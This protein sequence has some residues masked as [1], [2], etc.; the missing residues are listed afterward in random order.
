MGGWSTQWDVLGIFTAGVTTVGMVT[1]SRLGQQGKPLETT[2]RGGSSTR[3][4]NE[5]WLFF[6]LEHGLHNNW[7]YQKGNMALGSIA[8]RYFDWREFQETKNSSQHCVFILDVWGSEHF[9]CGV[10]SICYHLISYTDF[11]WC[12]QVFPSELLFPANLLRS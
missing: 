12:L 7:K 9:S 6:L 3:M 4:V 10:H 5:L 11:I 1:W 2:E 8:R